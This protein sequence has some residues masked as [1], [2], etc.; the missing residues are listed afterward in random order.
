MFN[1]PELRRVIARAC[2]T[3]ANDVAAFEKLAEGGWNRAFK[4]ALFGG[5][6]VIARLP[7]PCTLPKC[8]STLSEV[9]TMK[10]LKA[11]GIPVPTIYDWS[12]TTENT[13]GSE[14]ISSWRRYLAET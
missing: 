3:P 14:Y 5:R 7:F 13:V 4:A 10:L 11:N 12:A 2:H 9:A 8:F 1:V 6:E